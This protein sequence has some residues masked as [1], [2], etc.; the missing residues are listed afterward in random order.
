VQARGREGVDIA[1][2]GDIVGLFD[3]GLYRIGDTLCSGD[4]FE[5]AGIPSFSPE[6]FVR[7][8]VAEVLNRKSLNKGLDQLA[9]EG[10]VQLFTEP[11]AGTAVPIIG[12]VGPLQFD[13][14]QHRMATEY[15]V[16]LKLTPL[17]YKMARW[18]G[19]DTDTDLFRFS[20]TKLLEDRDGHAVVLAKSPWY[21]ERL[22]EKHPELVLNPTATH[23]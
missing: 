14:L 12:A 17:P 8:E 16:A 4:S 22:Q 2:P 23:S 19:P 1:Y 21:L 15:K 3:P 6:H 20:E 18:L 11:G 5:F 9:Q 10:A 13:V 7:V